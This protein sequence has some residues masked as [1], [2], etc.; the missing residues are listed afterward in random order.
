MKKAW[1]NNFEYRPCSK[2]CFLEMNW[3]NNCSQTK[4]NTG[5]LIKTSGAEKTLNIPNSFP[6]LFWTKRNWICGK[7]NIRF[8]RNWLKFGQGV[9]F[10]ICQSQRTALVTDEVIR[11]VV[12]RRLWQTANVEPYPPWYNNHAIDSCCLLNLICSV[13]EIAFFLAFS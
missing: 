2:K 3:K 9:G 13:H 12:S 7:S 10:V 1:V 4:E 8:D 11:K 6:A 5:V